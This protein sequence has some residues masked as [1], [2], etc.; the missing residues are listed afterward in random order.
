MDQLC[1]NLNHIEIGCYVGNMCLNNI[2][3]ADDICCFA[4]RIKGLQ[5]LTNECVRYDTVHNIVLIETVIKL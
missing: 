4:P 3:C 1:N 2:K 5:K